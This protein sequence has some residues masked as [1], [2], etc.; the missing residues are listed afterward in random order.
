M[1][2]ESEEA[3]GDGRPVGGRVGRLAA[4]P[5]FRAFPNPCSIICDVSNTPSQTL[6]IEVFGPLVAAFLLFMAAVGLRYF[7]HQ[8][9][10]RLTPEQRQAARDSFRNRLVH[11]K[12]GEVEQ[13][14]KAF[15]PQRL[16][17]L[18]TDHPTILSEE[19]EI[20]RPNPDGKPS[21]A[22]IEA[23]LPLDLESQKYTVDL[24]ESGWGQGFCFATDG[25]GNFYWVPVGETRQL[26]APVF[27]ACHDP[28]GN[29]Q[30]APSLEDFLS[31]PRTSHSHEADE[32]STPAD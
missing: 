11:P 25:A 7:W 12:S 14:M 17:T 9:S 23:F 16:L 19:L 24:G 13:D 32:E 8:F 21:T 6:I 5:F 10:N 18:Y 4:A 27:F 30:V 1:V 20:Q 22:W 31:W 29:E 15:L 2:C 3:V 28:V 26:D